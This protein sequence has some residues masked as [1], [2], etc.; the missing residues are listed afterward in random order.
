MR[1]VTGN[2]QKK[3]SWLKKNHNCG[4]SSVLKFSLPLGS[5]VIE[6][7]TKQKKNAKNSKFEKHKIWH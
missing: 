1:T 2:I 7:K 3:V 5:H 6:N 4:R